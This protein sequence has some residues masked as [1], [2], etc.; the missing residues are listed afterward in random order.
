MSVGSQ[1]HFV[2]AHE[3]SDLVHEITSNLEAVE[4]PSRIILAGLSAHDSITGVTR[5]NLM[6]G[7]Y[8]V[9][10]LSRAL[11]D[12][13]WAQDELE[14]AIETEYRQRDITVL[15]VILRACAP[16]HYLSPF[17]S[18]GWAGSRERGLQRLATVIQLAPRI[19]LRQL[20]HQAF[21]HLVVDLLRRLGFRDIRQQYFSQDR[22]FDLMAK[23]RRRDPFGRYEEQIWLVEIKVATSVTDLETLQRLLGAQA[24]FP[25]PATVLFVTSGQLS[26]FAWDW[27]RNKTPSRTPRISILEGTD[28]KRL[29]MNRR[30]LVDKYF[31]T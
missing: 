22:T 26:S 2:Y 11:L 28:L 18:L 5:G 23:R 15:P 1:I 25:E 27:I 20:S 6:A 12:S 16:P 21:E 4:S 19:D 29:L 7:D 17:L 13:V 3:D 9:I 31:G 24:V 8:I 14:A 10:F 30:K